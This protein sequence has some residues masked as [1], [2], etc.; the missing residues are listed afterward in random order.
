MTFSNSETYSTEKCIHGVYRGFSNR[1][2][3]KSSSCSICMSTEY[4]D[5]T[6]VKKATIKKL[7]AAEIENSDLPGES[8]SAGVGTELEE[9]SDGRDSS[10]LE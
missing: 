5:R 2:G 4:V 6:P 3:A 1:L 10:F 8:E 9:L 7:V